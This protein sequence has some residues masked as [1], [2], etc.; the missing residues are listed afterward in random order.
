MVA[1]AWLRRL[2][3]TS[4]PWKPIFG[5][6]RLPYP[7]LPTLQAQVT[8]VIGILEA[9]AL[10]SVYIFEQSHDSAVAQVLVQEVP[11]KV[12]KLVLSSS[13]AGPMP[14]LAL[15]LLHGYMGLLAWL[16]DLWVL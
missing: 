2:S 15:W 10:E 8:G 6:S 9:E 3:P 7:P 1:C 16:P 11:H 5:S 4:P 13:V 14:R 12:V